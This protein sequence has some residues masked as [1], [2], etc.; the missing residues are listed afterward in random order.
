[1]YK[2]VTLDGLIDAPTSKASLSISELL[3][4]ATRIDSSYSSMSPAE[5]VLKVRYG[6]SDTLSL[7]RYALREGVEK[8][9]DDEQLGSA[10]KIRRGA[11]R[12]TLREYDISADQ[13]EQELPSNFD[14]SICYNILR[15]YF[16]SVDASDFLR[17]AYTS[18]L[19]ENENN[20][21]RAAEKLG[22]APGA[23]FVAYKKIGISCDHLTQ[24]KKNFAPKKPTEKLKEAKGEIQKT[25]SLDS[26][27]KRKSFEKPTLLPLEEITEAIVCKDPLPSNPAELVIKLYHRRAEVRTLSQE[28][29]RQGLD[30]T[31]GFFSQL[32]TSIGVERRTISYNLR[33]FDVDLEK[34][35]PFLVTFFTREAL[36]TLVCVHYRSDYAIPLV[37]AA[38]ERL[39]VEHEGSLTKVCDKL[40]FGVSWALN[41]LG[42]NVASYKKERKTSAAKLSLQDESLG[43]DLVSQVV[44]LFLKPTPKSLKF[45]R[46]VASKVDAKDLEAVG[47]KGYLEA[48]TRHSSETHPNFEAYAFTCIRGAIL[49][50]FP[51]KKDF[52]F[53]DI[54][55]MG[56]IEEEKMVLAQM[57]TLDPFHEAANRAEEL[58]ALRASLEMLDP[59]KRRILLAHYDDQPLEQVAFE[60]DIPRA[61]IWTLHREALAELNERMTL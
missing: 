24:D 9:G 13:R 56:D 5:L 54:D 59:L 29:V 43:K 39:L 42:I 35:D 1:M 57:E 6:H 46:R 27:K 11:I 52:A 7:V 49:G 60:L 16:N 19:E 28:L 2:E 26:S 50:S 41:K 31:G 33:A 14:Q 20:A 61:K 3:E 25:Q 55:E 34:I 18:F 51:K 10:L 58:E 17:V 37:R 48:R 32:A 23:V 8:I 21:T 4:A 38:Y 36:T 40:G 30:L 44:S 15:I 22:I 53:C 45:I 12:R 47:W